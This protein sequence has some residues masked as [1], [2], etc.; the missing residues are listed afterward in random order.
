MYVI[1]IL[2]YL[3]HRVHK[4]QLY[5]QCILIIIINISI[6]IHFITEFMYIIYRNGELLFLQCH[7][8]QFQI[9]LK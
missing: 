1:Q 3:T 8:D 4:N 7:V 2:N 9:I 6:Y 5:L